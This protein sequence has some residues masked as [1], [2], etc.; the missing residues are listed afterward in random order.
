M[1]HRQKNGLL[2]VKGNPFS[3]S[4]GY[5]LINYTFKDLKG[6]EIKLK[7]IEAAVLEKLT[8][9]T[10]LNR[11]REN[12]LFFTRPGFDLKAFKENIENFTVTCLPNPVTE[13]SMFYS[14]ACELETLKNFLGHEEY[15]KKIGP[16]FDYINIIMKASS[17]LNSKSNF[18]FVDTT[19]TSLAYV[20]SQKISVDFTMRRLNAKMVMKF[21]QFDTKLL[22]DTRVLV[23]QL[24]NTQF[25]LS[26]EDITNF[27][28]SDFDSNAAAKLIEYYQVN[29]SFGIPQNLSP[30]LATM[31]LDQE[32]ISKY[33]HI[34]ESI[35]EQRRNMKY[36]TQTSTET[37]NQS[38]E[39][40]LPLAPLAPL[41]PLEGET[42]KLTK[43]RSLLNLFLRKK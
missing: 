14:Y 2:L 30:I 4:K 6:Y 3:N 25:P 10:E 19:N 37:N 9:A 5:S 28:E 18:N 12:D 16:F 29:P 1:K 23:S 32:N 31:G 35:E 34:V 17:D 11:D 26:V 8:K 24:N 38:T 39:V 41:A 33:V 43:S 27:N 15:N 22:Y 7:R 21:S 20:D 13:L 36:L 40:T 42:R